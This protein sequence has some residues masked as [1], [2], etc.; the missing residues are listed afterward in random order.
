[1]SLPFPHPVNEHTLHQACDLLKAGSLVAFPTE[2]VY[3][4]GAD[5]ECDDAV[6]S[7][8]A[9]KNRPSHNPLIVHVPSLDVA[10]RYGVLSEYAMRLANHFWPAPLTLVVASRP[11]NKL[12]SHLLG[13]G[14]TVALRIPSNTVAQSLLEVFGH[15]IAAPSANRSG[16]I[17]P[18][19]A[20]H[21]WREFHQNPGNL[22]AILD[23]GQAT[24]GLEST[25]VDCTQDMPVILRAG[26]I[27]QTD[28][29]NIVPLKD[30]YSK[31]EAAMISPGM[32]DSHYAP[33]AS[34]RLNA[35]EVGEGEALLAFGI[36]HMNCRHQR[37]LSLS[38]DVNEAAYH[39][40]DYLRQ[41]DAMDDVNAIAVMPIPE[42]GIGCAIND[43]LRRAAAKRT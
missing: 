7:I 12:S 23:G 38:G 3:G 36:H 29:A 34:V 26:S 11:D 2:T 42:T 27:T 18:T 24:I 31:R 20:Q 14:N 6:A 40:Y 30:S 15:G 35:S 32:L 25:V 16:K 8:Y 28:I 19:T 21:V 33:D 37:N 1:M 39:L 10:L 4:L 13:T 41:L 9:T 5:A 43:R 17:S 22:A